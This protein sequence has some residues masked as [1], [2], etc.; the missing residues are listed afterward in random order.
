VHGPGGLGK[1]RLMIEVAASLR[2]AG[3]MA[4]FLDPPPSDADVARQRWQALDDLIAN[5]NGDGLPMVIDYAEARQSEVKDIAVRLSRRP[6]GDALPIRLVLLT[7]TAGEW[8]D[9][10]HDETPEIQRLFRRDA[11]GPAV[12]P[13][14]A[15]ATPEQRRDLFLSSAQAMA[16]ALAAQ[17]YAKPA[18][19][20]GCP[21][22]ERRRP[23]AVG[24]ATSSVRHVPQQRRCSAGGGETPPLQ[25]QAGVR[26]GLTGPTSTWISSPSTRSG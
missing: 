9:T 11:R 16:P 12:I 8:W 26:A 5:G 7:R 18:G 15:I 21:A 14:P 25:Y 24:D 2:E 23:A 4:G 13:L 19:G 22:P 10:L 20:R 17:G 1:T 6:D 3:W